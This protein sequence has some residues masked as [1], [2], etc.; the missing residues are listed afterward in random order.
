VEDGGR[1]TGGKKE[2]EEGWGEEGEEKGDDLGEEGRRTTGEE[3]WR[4]LEERRER[5][6]KERE[7]RKLERKER[8]RG[9][10]GEKKRERRRNVV[11]RGVEG[12]SAE[13]RNRLIEGIM[14]EELRRRVELREFRERR[15]SVGMVLIVKM[16]KVEEKKELLKR[17]WEIRMNWGV[18]VDEDLTMEERRVRWKLVER[19]RGRVVVTTNRRIWIDG[20]AWGWDLEK[21]R[22]YEETEETEEESDE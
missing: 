20:R 14:R 21:D 15:G 4:K 9:E 10:E 16:G 8:V 17:G 6:R 12:G 18:G 13:E 19:A 5:V 2:E 22:W 7:K 11:W 1:G 3:V